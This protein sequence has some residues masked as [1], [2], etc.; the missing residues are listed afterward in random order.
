MP[1]YPGTQIVGLKYAHIVNAQSVVVKT[2]GGV[3]GNIVINSASSGATITVIDS[4]SAGTLTPVIA[5]AT[6]GANVTTPNSAWFGS[7]SDTVDTNNGILVV[8]TGT[9]DLTVLYN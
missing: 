9:V 2:T 8:T 4:K 3:I 7:T 1:Q 6:L 5:I